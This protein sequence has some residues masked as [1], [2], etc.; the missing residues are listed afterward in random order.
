LAVLALTPAAAL[1]QGWKHYDFSDDG[2]AV[3]L[4]A[5]PVVSRGQFHADGGLTV[6][7]TVYTAGQDGIVFSV[8]VADFS[9]TSI[10]QEAAIDAAVKAL[11]TQGELK[12]NVAERIDREF[13]RELTIAGRDQ[14]QSTA[15][16]F[17][18]G[19]KL[20]EV[21]GKG[22]PPDPKQVSGLANR[23]QQSLEFI[24][25]GAEAF[26]PENRAGGQ[27]PGR[28]FGPGGR[29][30]PPPPEA[31]ADCLGK[32]EGAQVQHSL[33]DGQLTPATCVQTPEGL[34]ARPSRPPPGAGPPPEG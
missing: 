8:T 20:Y 13:G 29:R 31:F 3:Q 1:A 24:G 26:R 6:P 25:L 19:R 2:F 11:S 16:V 14:S 32:T 10:G 18:V 34:A 9:G 17:F 15:A 28:G 12:V 4:P 33:P 30:G 21:V 22:L 5:E 27:G 23:F 7:E